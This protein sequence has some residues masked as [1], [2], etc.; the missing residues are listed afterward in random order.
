VTSLEAMVAV[1]DTAL[2]LSMAERFVRM[3]PDDVAYQDY[4]TLI[5]R[6]YKE[7]FRQYTDPF[8]TKTYG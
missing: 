7:A 3:N 2:Q 6:R 1:R 4:A 8:G 5:R